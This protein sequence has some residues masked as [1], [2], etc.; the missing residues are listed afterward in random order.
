MAR[1]TLIQV[2]V[3]DTLKK[4][5]DSLFADLGLDTPTAI[6]IFLKQAIK[7]QGLPFDVVQSVP[8][9][10][11]IAAMEEANRISRDPATKK[12]KDFSELLAEVQNEV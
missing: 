6:R 7:K 3:E 2:R 11:T 4:D 10:E 8:N 9:A 5:A 12:Y 1:N